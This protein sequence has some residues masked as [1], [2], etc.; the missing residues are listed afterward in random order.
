MKKRKK[1]NIVIKWKMDKNGWESI[2]GKRNSVKSGRCSA[3]NEF[4]NG[5]NSDMS[6]IIHRA[7]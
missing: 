7:K 1:E 3:I 5:Q 2:K 4:R 6:Q